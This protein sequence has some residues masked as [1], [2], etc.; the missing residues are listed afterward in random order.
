[1]S[2]KKPRSCTIGPIKPR[3]E[4]RPGAPCRRT[5]RSKRVE[6]GFTLKTPTPGFARRGSWEIMGWTPVRRRGITTVWFTVC[7]IALAGL[8]ALALDTARYNLAF[9]QLQV[10]ADSSA[11]A[12]LNYLSTGQSQARQLAVDT[13]IRNI[14]DG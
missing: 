1:R 4:D 14:C 2:I 12:E 7:G 13:A 8:F 9:H 6:H 3:V 5:A 11:L 10:T